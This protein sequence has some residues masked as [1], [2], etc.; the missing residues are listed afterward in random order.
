LKHASPFF[1]KEVTHPLREKEG[2]G[3]RERNFSDG[4]VRIHSKSKKLLYLPLL[5]ETSVIK[6]KYFYGI[7]KNPPLFF[8]FLKENFFASFLGSNKYAEES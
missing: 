3:D 4:F 1:P 2:F 7:Y 5:P 8:F 6:N